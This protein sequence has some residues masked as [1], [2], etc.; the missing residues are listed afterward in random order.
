MVE[1]VLNRLGWFSPV[2]LAFGVEFGLV[3]ILSFFIANSWHSIYVSM[4]CLLIMPADY[5][6]VVFYVPRG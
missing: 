6:S 5:L 4:I 2:V 1:V 3:L